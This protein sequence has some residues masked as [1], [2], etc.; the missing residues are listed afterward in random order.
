MVPFLLSR[1][2]CRFHDLNGELNILFVRKSISKQHGVQRAQKRNAPPLSASL[3]FSFSLSL[4][5]SLSLFPKSEATRLSLLLLLR[6][7]RRFFL[8][9]LFR[10]GGGG[11]QE[12]KGCGHTKKENFLCQK[13]LVL[14]FRFLF[15]PFFSSFAFSLSLTRERESRHTNTQRK[16]THCARKERERE[17]EKSKQTDIHEDA[18]VFL[19]SRSS[20]NACIEKSEREKPAKLRWYRERPPARQTE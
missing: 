12:E 2:S 6:R 10:G 9:F 16:R 8:F 11:G 14:F 1:S 15:F 20:V 3:L 17:R 13:W 18:S 4:S 5:L 19:L 7:R